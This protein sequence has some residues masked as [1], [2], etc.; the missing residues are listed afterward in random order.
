MKS[1]V[2]A[3]DEAILLMQRLSIFVLFVVD[4]NL[5]QLDEKNE[6]ILWARIVGGKA[7]YWSDQW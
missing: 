2:S 3:T 7:S 6:L 5:G 1:N 4:S